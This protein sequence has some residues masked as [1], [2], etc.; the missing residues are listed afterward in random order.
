MGIRDSLIVMRQNFFDQVA[1]YFQEKAV[2]FGFPELPGM[3]ILPN[4]TFF[5]SPDAI[6]YE[7]EERRLPF[8]PVTFASNYLEIILGSIP[9]PY[10][11][12]KVFY[13]SASDGYFSFY[14]ENYKNIYF[15]PNFIS[16]FLQIRCNFCVDISFL[17]V[18]RETLF[19]ILFLYH[20]IVSIRIVLGWY[21][22]I[23][24]YTFPF[25][26]F[27][28][29][30]DW[31]EDA[32]YG[33]LPPI[34]G[35][36]VA[37]PILTMLI[38]K[39]ADAVNHLVFTMPFLPG[40]AIKGK[41]FIDGELKN[42]LIFKHLPILWYKYPIPNELRTYWFYERQDILDYLQQAYKDLGVQ[43]TPDN[44]ETINNIIN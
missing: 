7:L 43:F 6:M 32:T 2:H 44:I 20:H 26:Y 36:S 11:L 27:I 35:L 22:I 28:A 42:V 4:K 3:P 8:P 9:K 34:T 24:P 16:E 30:V 21:L 10:E 13:E 19:F 31:I 29:L 37:A 15:L 1:I 14:I 5:W 40:E 25:S 41:R 12:P 18:C 17:E 23:N 38:G 33:F 39:V